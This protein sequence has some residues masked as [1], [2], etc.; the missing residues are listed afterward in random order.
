[1]NRNSCIE[2]IVL[3]KIPLVYL[4]LE[5]CTVH[6]PA[7]FP[8]LAPARSE[9]E[10][11]NGWGPLKKF[12]SGVRLNVTISVFPEPEALLA[13]QFKV[14]AVVESVPGCPGVQLPPAPNKVK[15]FFARL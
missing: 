4:S 13:P 12:F 2:D 3:H 7:L 11:N 15:L 10:I 6:S 14:R 9:T 1:M 8:L 5:G